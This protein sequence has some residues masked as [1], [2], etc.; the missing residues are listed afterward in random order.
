MV[1]GGPV[2]LL[3]VRAS[4]VYAGQRAPPLAPWARS[5]C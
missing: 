4:K 5:R 1:P 3:A 2:A